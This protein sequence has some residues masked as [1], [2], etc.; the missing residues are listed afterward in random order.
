MARQSWTMQ[1]GTVGVWQRLPHGPH[2]Q[3]S[4][5]AQARR[6]RRGSGRRLPGG[7]VS[8]SLLLA[9]VAGWANV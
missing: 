5:R 1:R 8:A 6:A 4:A 9:V 2:S 3:R 7:L